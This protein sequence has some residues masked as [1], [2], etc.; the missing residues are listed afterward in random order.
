MVDTPGWPAEVTL[1][2]SLKQT[3]REIQF[4]TSLC[5]PG[6]HCFLVAIQANA[7]FTDAHRN[8][9]QQHLELLSE[10]VWSH[11]IVLFTCGDRLRKKTIEQYI[12]CSGQ[13]LQWLIEKCG[14]RYHVIN[15]KENDVSQVTE[16]L[17]KIKAM[18][19]FNG[20]SHYEVDS[21]RLQEIT[22]QRK[23]EEKRAGERQVRVYKQ[24]C[25]LKYV[26]G[27]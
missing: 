26:I 23:E 5:L 15:N 4:S 25:T 14:D 27:K 12:K 16:L 24:H 21:K 17:D 2:E 10:R 18:V 6:P 8:A 22:K 9:I 7:T 11:T 1:E 20:S 19:A 3:K 13:P